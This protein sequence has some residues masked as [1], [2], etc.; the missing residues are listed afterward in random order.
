MRVRSILANM[1]SLHAIHVSSP[2]FATRLNNLVL[3][4]SHQNNIN[5]R[6][7]IAA[8]TQ[9]QHMASVN[10]EHMAHFVLSVPP[11]IRIMVAFSNNTRSN[12]M[13]MLCFCVRFEVIT[14]TRRNVCMYTYTY[15]IMEW[16]IIAG[17]H[18]KLG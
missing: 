14:S 3:F 8:S 11:C 1:M 18:S 15:H 4:S 12:Y 5:T 17:L 2:R 7:H 9:I 6:K 10:L 16:T 13:V